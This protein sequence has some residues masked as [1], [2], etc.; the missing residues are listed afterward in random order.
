MSPSL[1]RDDGPPNFGGHDARF[2][3]DRGWLLFLIAVFLFCLSRAPF[4]GQWDSFDYVKEVV[5]RHL[6][7]LGVGRPVFVAYNIVL[8][9]IARR[10]LHLGALQAEVVMMTGIILVGAFGILLFRYFAVL[11]IG[12]EGGRLAT[13]GLLLSPIYVMYSASVMT[14]IPMLVALW[15]AAIVLWRAPESGSTIRDLMSGALFGAAI[16]LR[17]QALTVGGAFLWILWARRTDWRLRIGSTVIF[18]LST[19]V[20][21]LAPVVALYFLDP[22]GFW[23]RLQVWVNAIPTGGSHFLRNLEASL[24][25]LVAVCPGAW[26]GATAAGLHRCREGRA[27]SAAGNNIPQHSVR[28]T[29]DAHQRR[30]APTIGVL[31]ALVL[32]V[33]ALWKDADVQ[34]HPRYLLIAL[35]AALMVCA[36]IY[37]RRLPSRRAAVGWALLQLCVFAVAWI[38]MQPFR[39]MQYDKK[40]YAEMVRVAVPGRGLLIAG[41]F[42]PSFDYYRALGDRPEW[43]ILWSGW[44]WSPRLA[45]ECIHQAWKGNVP[46]YVCDGPHGWWYFEDEWLDLYLILKKCPKE[47]IKPGLIRVYPPKMADIPSIH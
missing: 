9:E 17:E 34:M 45:E 3:G 32:P 29:P 28:T 35:P 1:K 38:L 43:S 14:E 36:A 8:W 42:S 41:S 15:G 20:V 24:L 18:G 12:P 19:L 23:R 16:G 27:I 25:F 33:A 37:C 11:V 10:L 7:D 5:N 2:W 31:C 6:S 40:A 39:Q 21:T 4:L 26:L 46:V 13:L 44:E 30:L 47:T 22:Q